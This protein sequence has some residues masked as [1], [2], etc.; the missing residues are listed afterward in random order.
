MKLRISNGATYAVEFKANSESDLRGALA[1]AWQ[2]WRAWENKQLTFIPK[3][4]TI[5]RAEFERMR[6][7]SLPLHLFDPYDPGAGSEKWQGVGQVE[8]KVISCFSPFGED[9][10]DYPWLWNWILKTWTVIDEY[11]RFFGYGPYTK[12]KSTMNE[13]IEPT[14]AEKM[15]KFKRVK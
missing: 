1:D 11:A 4:Q 8:N 7:K 5:K 15:R 14:R 2:Q 6:A 12:E 10:N 13:I 9:K 3:Y